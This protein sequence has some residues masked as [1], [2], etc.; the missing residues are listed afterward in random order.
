MMKKKRVQMKRMI[1]LFT[2][3][4]EMQTAGATNITLG[5]RAGVADTTVSH[6][7]NRQPMGIFTAA[8]IL[9]ALDQGGY[10]YKK[11]YTGRAGKNQFF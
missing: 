2:L 5:E 9:Q 6:A 4:A 8:C 1:S 7:R 10:E 3:D 11:R